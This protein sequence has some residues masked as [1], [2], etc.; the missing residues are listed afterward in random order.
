MLSFQ[1]SVTGLHMP[2]DETPILGVGAGHDMSVGPISPGVR[3]LRRYLTDCSVCQ[4]CLIHM[5]N[6]VSRTRPV[7]VPFQKD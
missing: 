2:G 7:C 3:G 6:N 4:H 5:S 1:K